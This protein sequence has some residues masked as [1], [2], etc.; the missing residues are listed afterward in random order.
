MHNLISVDIQKEW[1][2]IRHY[3]LTSQV[4][5]LIQSK[6]ILIPTINGLGIH[7]KTSDRVIG[8]YQHQV[9]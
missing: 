6:H 9:L 3:W 2:G 5:Q 7:F 8:Q 4:T 1:L